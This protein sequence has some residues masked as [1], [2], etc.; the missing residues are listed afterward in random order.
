MIQEF[1]GTELEK[2]KISATELEI[3]C[4]LPHRLNYQSWA[5]YDQHYGHHPNVLNQGHRNLQHRG[6][7]SQRQISYPL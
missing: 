5:L 7:H 1:S 4:H 3:M 6:V 2:K